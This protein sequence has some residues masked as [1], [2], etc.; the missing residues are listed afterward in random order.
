[1]RVYIQSSGI[2]APL[3]WQLNIEDK[4]RR[5][6]ARFHHRLSEVRIRLRDV[7]GP[8]GGVDKEALVTADFD[9]GR[10]IRIEDQDANGRA[11]IHRALKRLSETLS[12]K[13]ARHE[14][15]R[16]RHANPWFARRHRT[17]HPII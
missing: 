10:R 2:A 6:L 17:R 9:G 1:M 16:R 4:T 14:S 12:R 5:V 11:A 13:L 15:L 8:R 7:N 3:A